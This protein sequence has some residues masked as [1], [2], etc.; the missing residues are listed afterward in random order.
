LLFGV[1]GKLERETDET[2]ILTSN[3]RIKNNFF[4]KPPC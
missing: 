3:K 4:I 2:E 1:D